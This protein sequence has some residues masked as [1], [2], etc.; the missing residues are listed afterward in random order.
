[1][2]QA[3]PFKTN[4]PFQISNTMKKILSIL[5][6]TIVFCSTALSQIPGPYSINDT[7]NETA[8][9]LR[10]RG[11]LVQGSDGTNSVNLKVDSAGVVQTSETASATGST[12]NEDA[13]HASGAG[14]AFVLGVGN[15]A[16]S[17]LAADG[18]YIPLAV[19]TKGRAIV[20]GS[21]ASDAVYSGNPV[22]VGGLAKSSN[23]TA[24][25]TGD[26]VSAIFDLLGAQIVRPYALSENSISGT[27]SATDT[28]ATDIIAA[29]AAGIR[30]YLTQL[31]CSNGSATGVHVSITDGASEKYNYWVAATTTVPISFPVPLRG[32]AATAWKFTSSASVTTLKCSAS[33][34][35]AAN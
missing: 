6:A 35:I 1:M 20:T 29:Q 15:E 16:L 5:A 14:G 33:G 22:P 34:F 7:V 4:F 23:I 9:A 3:P 12:K 2:T 28:T 8:A 30:T 10:G 27:G 13:V 26:V 25:A 31:T 18:D 24:V 19:D 11:V 17:T 21:A 32:T